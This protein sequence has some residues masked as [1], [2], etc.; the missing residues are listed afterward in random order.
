MSTLEWIV[1]VSG[2]M[3]LIASSILVWQTRQNL[4]RDA[5]RQ[6]NAGLLRPET[7]PELPADITPGMLATLINETAEPRDLL[8]TLVDLAQRGALRITA[9]TEPDQSG[10]PR[11]NDWL[12]SGTG[13]PQKGLRDFEQTLLTFT[14]SGQREGLGAT[15]LSALAAS[16]ARP[17]PR[18]RQQLQHTTEAQGW[19]DADR[20][21]FHNVW[22]LTGALLLL[23]GLVAAVVMIIGGLAGTRASLL[24]VLGA[25]M[26]AVA[27]AI[28]AS[29]GTL[30]TTHTDTGAQVR[31]QAL[32]YRD[33][34]AEF[35]AEQIE[36]ERAAALYRKHLAPA[37]VFGLGEQLGRSFDQ[38]TVRASR[39]GRT[40]VLAHPW[41]DCGQLHQPDSDTPSGLTAAIEDF[42]T[43]GSLLVCRVLSEGR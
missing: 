1:L 40:I 27:G 6:D 4:A 25:V 15:T 39:W 9:L 14:T 13:A 11:T 24:G 16:S 29:M 19:L 10:R 28:I 31:D 26:I 17:V 12:L 3:V 18:A 32:V 23:I 21:S 5:R 41:F 30:R 38:A 34:L 8:I 20:R 42:V 36:P 35:G 2:A 7:D 37:L 33:W 22:G 43:E